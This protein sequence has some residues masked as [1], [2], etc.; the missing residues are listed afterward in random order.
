MLLAALASAADLQVDLHLDTPTQ[1]HRKKLGLDGAGLESGLLAMRAGGTNL[2]VMV[3]WPPKGSGEAHVDRLLG[4]VEAEEARLEEVEL[5]RDPESARRVAAEGRVGLLYALE[6]AH[7]IETEG[8]AGLRRLQARG[9]AILGLTWSNS[10]RFAGSSGDG[11][12]GLSEAGR[13]LVAEAVRLGVLVDLS[14]ASRATTLEVC[15]AARAPVIASHSDAAAVHSHARNLDDEQI[16]CIAATG[17][18][19]GL[20]FHS[21]FLGAPADVEKVADHA[22]HLREVGGLGV[23]ALGSDFDGLIDPPDDLPTAAELPKLWAELR[24]RGW[25]EAELAAVKGENFLRAWAAARS[26]AAGPGGG[27]D[28]ER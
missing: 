20:N 6:G 14:H 11:G 2:A 3:L 12:G 7:G 23:V 1:L 8:L 21:P 16:R 18:V 9:L 27:L 19:I 4:L 5:V 10:N 17:G 13:A 22:E 24:R 25:T 15:G 26:I 28:P